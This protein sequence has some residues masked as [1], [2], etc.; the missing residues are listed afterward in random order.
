M[1]GEGKDHPKNV[2]SKGTWVEVRTRRNET[3]R[4]RV[5]FA[6]RELGKIRLAEGAGF[7][8]VPLKHVANIKELAALNTTQ[9]VTATI[10]SP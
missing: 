3:F 4:G 6:S 1:F 7:W 10:P 2:P 8:D 9:R 5:R